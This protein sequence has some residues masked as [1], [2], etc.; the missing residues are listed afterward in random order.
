[1]VPPE[2]AAFF[3]SRNA[4]VW[5]SDPDCPLAPADGDVVQRA[6]ELPEGAQLCAWCAA[7][8]SGDPVLDD[9]AARVLVELRC[10]GR[11]RCGGTRADAV[12]W[13]FGVAEF[14]FHGTAGTWTDAVGAWA[15]RHQSAAYV[16]EG[17]IQKILQDPQRNP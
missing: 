4:R 3:R 13:K 6:D 7:K 2:T 1:M 10:D 5:F 16:A 8:G 11:L 15:I 17:L 14:R 9:L 12:V